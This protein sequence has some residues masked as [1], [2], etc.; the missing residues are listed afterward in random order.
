MIILGNI[1]ATAGCTT[2]N[3]ITLGDRLG[4]RRFA[5]HRVAWSR[6]QPSRLTKDTHPMPRPLKIGVQL[7]EVEYDYTWDQLAT[8]ARTAEDIGLDSIWLGDHLMYRYADTTKAPRGPYEAWTT[9]A[10]LAAITS[11]VQ[12]GPLVA[13]AL[14]HSPPMIAKKAAT[15]DQVSNG[16]FILGLG[17]GWHEPEYRGFGVPFDHRFSRFTEAFTIIRDLFETGESTFH[18]EFYDIDGALL[19]PKP[20]QSG[21]PP[22]MI[23]SYGRKML[24]HTLPHV[25]MWNAWS[26]DYGNTRDGL[27]DLLGLVD[28]TCEMVGRDPKT[29]VRTVCP[30]VRMEGSSGRLSDY[31]GMPPLIEGRDTETLAAELH[32]YAGMG[33][34]H[35][36]LVLD[37]ITADSIAA[38]KPVLD[39]LDA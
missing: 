1:P 7:P 4:P 33:I 38:L 37:P 21:G 9:L 30:M 17:A 36:M 2:L 23:G 10:A 11:R 22:I 12:L 34:G 19:F 24:A 18:G 29:L 28:A 3:L 13:S 5:P 20:V 39:L 6:N 35:V 14:F 16:R 15:L 32:A 8:M 26:A 25:P 27:A 31:A